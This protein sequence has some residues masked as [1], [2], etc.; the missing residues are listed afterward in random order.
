MPV[1]KVHHPKII[2]LLKSLK[3]LSCGLLSIFCWVLYKTH[4]YGKN[5]TTHNMLV[6]KFQPSLQTIIWLGKHEFMLND[7]SPFY[8]SASEGASEIFDHK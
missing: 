7:L 6:Y 4:Y 1:H 5:S 8:T 2:P 3:T